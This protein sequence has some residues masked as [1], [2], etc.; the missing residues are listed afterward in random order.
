[1]QTGPHYHTHLLLV[2][3]QSPKVQ[4]PISVT[5]TSTDPSRSL[6]YQAAH[7]ESVWDVLCNRDLPTTSTDPSRSLQYQAAHMESVWDILCNRDLS[8]D[9]ATCVSASQQVSTV[10]STYYINPLLVSEGMV[11]NI[12]FYLQMGKYL[13][14]SVIECY[15]MVITSILRATFK[16]EVEYKLTCSNLF[17]MLQHWT[18]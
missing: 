4:N 12:L 3:V 6:Q 15:R 11:S 9:V 7:M 14:T 8:V 5:T 13:G 17:E 10:C 18:S 16:V 2:D 1:M